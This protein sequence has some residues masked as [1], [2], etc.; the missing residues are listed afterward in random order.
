MQQSVAYVEE[1]PLQQSAPDFIP[2]EPKEKTLEERVADLRKEEQLFGQELRDIE[3]RLSTSN[4]EENH[5]LQ[6]DFE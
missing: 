4:I 3:N 5:P 2:S 1:E 6:H